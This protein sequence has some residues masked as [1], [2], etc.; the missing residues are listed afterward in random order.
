MVYRSKKG[1]HN[2]GH[3][4]TIHCYQAASTLILLLYNFSVASLCTA[5]IF[6][7]VHSSLKR[8]YNGECNKNVDKK[9]VLGT[10]PY[11][12]PIFLRNFKESD[13]NPHGYVCL[14]L[15]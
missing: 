1:D 2:Q 9:H 7:T 15:V 6:M 14:I 10:A 8:H 3:Q 4:Q 13:R 11:Y 5:E 12:C